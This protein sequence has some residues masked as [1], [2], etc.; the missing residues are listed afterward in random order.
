MKKIITSI[1]L[2]F[3]LSA[4]ATTI[5]SDTNASALTDFSTATTTFDASGATEKTITLTVDATKGDVTAY[6]FKSTQAGTTNKILINGTSEYGLNIK[7][8]LRKLK[9]LLVKIPVRFL[10]LM[11]QVPLRCP[12]LRNRPLHQTQL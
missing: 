11:G 6:K 5:T 1:A 12:L 7:K 8:L 10:R 3:A 2:L 9:F 4:N